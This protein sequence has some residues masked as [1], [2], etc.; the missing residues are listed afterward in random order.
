MKSLLQGDLFR[1]IISTEYFSI[2]R[3]RFT[4]W[5]PSFLYNI[6]K[7]QTKQRKKQKN[8]KIKPVILLSRMNVQSGRCKALNMTFIF[9]HVPFIL[10]HFS[11]F[12]WQNEFSI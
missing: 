4:V 7:Y 8:M 3:F 11:S 10:S 6:Y 9:L 2:D 5:S 12:M 1:F